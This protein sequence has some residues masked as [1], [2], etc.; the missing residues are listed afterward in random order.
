VVAFGRNAPFDA[1]MATPSIMQLLLF[2]RFLDAD[3]ASNAI[4]AKAKANNSN[5]AALAPSEE[6]ASSPDGVA[7]DAL[8]AAAAD[9]QAS[10]AAWVG[11]LSPSLGPLVTHVQKKACAVLVDGP[12]APEALA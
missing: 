1:L 8:V 7:V 10:M 3:S 5:A 12:S 4:N 11:R 6:A 2:D 9:V